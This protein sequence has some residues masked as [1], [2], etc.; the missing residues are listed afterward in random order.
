MQ[1]H[2]VVTEDKRLVN[3]G[4]ED[5]ADFVVDN[6]TEEGRYDGHAS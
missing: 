5:R 6:G 1:P 2:A 3:P 4:V